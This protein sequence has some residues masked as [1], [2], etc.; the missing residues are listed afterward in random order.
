MSH[1]SLLKAVYSEEYGCLLSCHC[2]ALCVYAILLAPSLRPFTPNS[3]LVHH[4]FFFPQGCACD[5]CN[6]PHLRSLYLGSPGNSSST[7][8][9]APFLRLLVLRGYLTKYEVVKVYH[10]PFLF[11]SGM[12]WWYLQQWLAVSSFF[13]SEGTDLSTVFWHSVPAV[14]LKTWLFILRSTAWASAWL[15]HRAFLACH[16]HLLFWAF[17]LCNCCTPN[18]SVIFPKCPPS[19]DSSSKCFLARL[20]MNVSLTLCGNGTA[21]HAYSGS[22]QILPEL[23]TALSILFWMLV[24][25]YSQTAVPILVMQCPY[26]IHVHLLIMGF[27]SFPW[28]LHCFW[29]CLQSSAFTSSKLVFT[30]VSISSK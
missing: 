27:L 13:P 1:C 7:A 4:N 20:L 10:F 25:P 18:V 30:A 3:L 26:I 17:P 14:H 8:P 29:I 15:P 22:G 5:I 6:L 11:F 28:G 16:T 24:A 12:W 23:T 9:T 21:F 19:W 2:L